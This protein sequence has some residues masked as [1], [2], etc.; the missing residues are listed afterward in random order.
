MSAL[1]ALRVS[2]A[3]QLVLWL[4]LASALQAGTA[5]VVR[6]MHTVRQL[7]SQQGMSALLDTTVRLDWQHHFHALQ[8]ATRHPPE[9]WTSRTARFAAL[10]ATAASPD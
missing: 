6:L 4:R 3:A 8:G 1:A 7:K 5:L 10:A 2:T 9:T